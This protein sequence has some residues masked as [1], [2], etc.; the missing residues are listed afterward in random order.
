MAHTTPPKSETALREETVLALWREHDVFKRSM[1]AP[2]PHGEFVFYDGPPFATGLP[3]AGSLLSSVIKD[4][5]P[6]YKTM[7]G[8]RV[9]RRWG[10]DTHGLPIESI[11]EKKLGLKSKKDIEAMGID[12]FNEEA[13]SMVLQYVTDWEHYVERVG[14]WVD[15]A[16]S[17]KTMDNSYIESVWWGLSQAYRRGLMY[18]GRKVLMYCPHCETPLAKAEIAMDNSYQDVTEESVT[19]KFKVKSG[20]KIGD[21]DVPEDTFILAWTTTPWTLPGNVALAVGEEIEYVLVE[22]TRNSRVGHINDDSPPQPHELI[23]EYYLFAA[24]RYDYV[25][26]S[27]HAILQHS[28]QPWQYSLKDK[29]KKFKGA[30]LVGLQYEPL[31]EIEKVKSAGKPKT[32]TVVPADFVT[33]TDGTGVVHT[34]VIYGE[35]DYQLGVKED[36]PMV[37]LLNASGRFNDDAPLLVQGKYFKHHKNGFPQAVK[38]EDAEHF[39]KDDLVA[40]GL[41]FSRAQFTHSYPHCYRCNTPLI[42]NAITSWFLKINPD[43][44]EKMLAHN[45]GV[46][47]F[48]AHLKQGRFR[49]IVEN[50]PDWTISR[51]RYWASPLPIWKNQKTGEVVTI[52]SLAELKAHTKKSGNRYFIMRHG[53][54]LSNINGVLDRNGDPANILTEKG[55]AQVAQAGE[56]LREHAI[57]HIYASPLVRTRITAE[58]IA[59]S[60]G[61]PKERIIYDNRLLETGV[62]TFDGEPIETYHAFFS[63]LSEKMTK[64]PPDGENWHD[65]KTRMTGV[66]YELEAKNQNEHILIVSHSGPMEMLQAGIEGLTDTEAGVGIEDGRFALANGEVR[67]LPFVPLPHNASFE[68]DLHRP[69]IDNVSLVAAD[70]TPLVRIPEVVDCWVESGSMPFA[71][72]NYLGPES[73][74]AT[75]FQKRFPGDFI[76]EYIAQTRTWFYYMHAIGALLFDSLT[77]KNVVSTGTILAADGEKMSKS[78]GNYTDPLENFDRYGADAFRLYLMGSVVMQAEDLNFNDSELKDV[79]NRII[80]I[81]WNSYKFYDLNRGLYVPETRV[82]QSTHVLDRWILNETAALIELVTRSLDEYDTVRAVRAI[83]QFVEDYSTWYVRRSRDRMKSEDHTDAQYAIAVQRHVLMELVRVMAPIAPFIAESVYQGIGGE[84]VSVHLEQWPT[85]EA[86]DGS[87]RTAMATV[88]SLVSAALKL[89]SESGIKVRQPLASMTIAKEHDTLAPGYLAELKSELNVKEILFDA[90]YTGHMVSL[91]TTLTPSLIEEGAVRELVRHIQ[92]LRKKAGMAPSDR[93]QVVLASSDAAFGTLIAT[94]RSQILK[95][96]SLATLE[97]GNVPEDVEPVIIGEVQVRA[98]LVHGTH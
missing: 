49:H 46:N 44:K 55:L 28:L 95:G 92:D 57:T 2:A 47:W 27:T 41:L 96:A 25:E 5:I 93:A 20:Q 94:H 90:L 91:D 42:Y 40:R 31:Y 56:Q 38:G 83:G 80:N 67:E 98:M 29:S 18:E 82:T 69:Y 30:D 7:R 64:T 66:L 43:I 97:M 35:D 16:H 10:W 11:V 74:A 45:E 76:A 51:N 58:T 26:K 59:N 13:R 19:A 70:G 61:L 89:R 87:L 50:A 60:I 36:L 81:L 9:R 1:E 22:G 53:E 8:Y 17:Y 72:L 23:N 24:D 12:R 34:A 4:V 68:L 15:F 54:S 65:A 86:V 14:R 33:T 63:R 37:P 32:W 88:R 85:H 48:P 78:K 75:E 71:E 84:N 3:H 6:R 62:G 52:G 79:H 21:W 73:P 77:F 39:I